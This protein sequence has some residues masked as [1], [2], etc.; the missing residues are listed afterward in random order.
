MVMSV[1]NFCSKKFLLRREVAED[2]LAT[3]REKFLRR[4][5]P[6][7]EKSTEDLLNARKEGK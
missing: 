1:Q 2:L 4:E 5:V 6:L 3:D 7:R